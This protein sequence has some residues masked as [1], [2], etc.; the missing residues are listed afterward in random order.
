LARS[1]V[2]RRSLRISLKAARWSRLPWNQNIE[3]LALVIDRPPE[4][5]TLAGAP[6]DHLVEMPAI[7]R[8]GTARP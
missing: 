8:P 2:F 6:N 7:A 1:L 4:I 3:D 5:H